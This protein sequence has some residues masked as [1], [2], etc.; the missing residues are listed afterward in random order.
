MN[1]RIR[2]TSATAFLTS[3]VVFVGYFAFLAL[4][5][6]VAA[7]LTPAPVEQGDKCFRCYRTVVLTRLAAEIVERNGLAY[8]FRA[9]ACLA[10]YLTE[11]P[12]SRES[13]ARVFV[14]EY[15]SGVLI[16][17]E[18]LWFV[19]TV[20]DR[21]TGERDFVAFT[22]RGLADSYAREAGGSVVDWSGVMAEGARRVRIEY[23][24]ADPWDPEPEYL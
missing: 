21:W 20:I 1:S 24:S 3:L 22:L 12:Q 10:Q 18:R 23:Q 16:P 8:K 14:A 5:V 15:T 6:G 13:P 2:F 17:V 19:E 4:I 11:H 9:P 7:P